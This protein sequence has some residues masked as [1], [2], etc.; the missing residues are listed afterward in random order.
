MVKPIGRMVKQVPFYSGTTILGDGRVIMILD[1]PSIAAASHVAEQSQSSDEVQGSVA[2][3][4]QENRMPLVIFRSGSESWQAVP[5]ALVSRLEKIPTASIEYADGRFLVQYRGSILPLVAANPALDLRAGAER[6][7]IVFTDG[8]RNMGLAVEEIHDIVDDRLHVEMESGAPGI[9][10]TAVI[11]GR[12]TEVLDINAF[13]RQVDAHWFGAR[14]RAETRKRV[15][16]VDDS[17]FFLNIV[18]PALRSSNF[19]VALAND[20][21]EALNRLEQGE[22]Y[23]VIVSDIDMPRIDGFELARRISSHPRWGRIPL[24]ALTGRETAEDRAHAIEQGF[25]EFLRKFD[26]EAVLSAIESV[27]TESAEEALV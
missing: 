10:G 5:L 16:L 26:R 15:L 14:Q 19:E 11:A 4:S 12:S 20:G 2:E 3:E 1:V 23:D 7:V 17:P 24:L 6:P 13:L 25:D 27:T 21:Q 9:L 8:E 22:S 18:G